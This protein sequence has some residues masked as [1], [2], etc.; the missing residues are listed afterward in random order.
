MLR[1]AYQ[2]IVNA[3][4]YLNTG[5]RG[6]RASDDNRVVKMKKVF[7]KE[8]EGAW[9]KPWKHYDEVKAG[10]VLAE[11]ENG[12]KIIAEED[13]YAILPKSS[14]KI[15]GEWIYFGTAEDFPA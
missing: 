6:K 14:A 13:G 15:G 11:Y 5:E 2:A 8:S 12:D 1:L 3:I 9:A 4:N 10:E 7:Y